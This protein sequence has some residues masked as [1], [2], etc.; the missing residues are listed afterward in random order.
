MSNPAVHQGS[1]LGGEWSAT[2]QGDLSAPFYK[3]ALNVCLNAMP[4][5]EK[6]FVRRSGCQFLQPTYGRGTSRLLP[7]RDIGGVSYLISLTVVSSLGYAHFYSGTGPVFT[8]DGAFTVATSSSTSGI[9]TL[10]TTGATSWSVGDQFKF[11]SLPTASSAVYA[12]RVLTVKTISGTTITAWDDLGVAF[13]FD[14]GVNAMAAAQIVRLLRSTTTFTAT[15]YFDK[16]RSIQ[17]QTPTGTALFIVERNTAPQVIVGTNLAI[18]TASFKD[19]PYLDPQ[20]GALSPEAGTVSAYSGTI[21]FTPAVTTFVA[22]DVGRHIRLF[23]QPAAW[24]VGTTYTNGQTV[25]YNN[26]W[27][28]FVYSSGLAGVIPGTTSTIGGVA[29]SPWAPSPNAG[30]WAWGTISAQAGTSCTVVLTTALNSA[31]GA[32]ITVWRL[33]LFMAGRYPACGIFHKGRLWFGGCANG[34]A[35]GAPQGRFD[36]STTDD[37]YTFSPTD[38]NG[39]VADNHG[40]AYTASSKRAFNTIRWFEAIDTGGLLF[41]TA[42]SEWLIAATSGDALTPT[43][44]TA[45]EVTEYGSAE[46]EPVRAGLTVIFV[47]RFGRTV[48]EYLADAFSTRFGGRPINENAKHL[49]ASASVDAAGFYRLTYQSEKTP[50]IWALGGGT[51]LFGCT[52]RRESRFVTEPPTFSGWHR[53]LLYDGERVPVD[54]CALPGGSSTA[55]LVYLVLNASGVGITNYSIEVLRPLLDG[56]N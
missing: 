53:H 50:V 10:E 47:Q 14:S 7:Y 51:A 32:G 45:T 4:V 38:I 54:V 35:A 12:N 30:Q 31:N 25:T 40:I 20:G 27:W 3:Q 21:T 17:A 26:Q 28:V 24:A 5:A 43:T 39:N 22:A 15:T 8:T 19:G 11:Q 44:I 36:A 9:L 33:G 1:F 46:V 41:G 37:I 16:I 48:Y 29:V 18:S 23:S 6:A 34:A 13:T 49:V 55:D 52:Y 2:A 42:N 56:E